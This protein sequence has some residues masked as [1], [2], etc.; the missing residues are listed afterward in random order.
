MHCPN[1][2]NRGIITTLKVELKYEA[3][4]QEFDAYNEKMAITFGQYLILD[5]LI[6][7][8]N[9]LSILRISQSVDSA[10]LQVEKNIAILINR[11]LANLDEAASK[12]NKKEYYQITAKGVQLINTINDMIKSIKSQKGL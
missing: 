2:I 9:A 7:S 12:H 1:C 10:Q 8:Q 4:K 11:S 6:Q 5:L 3:I